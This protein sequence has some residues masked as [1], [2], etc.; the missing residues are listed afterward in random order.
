M[1]HRFLALALCGLC[2][3]VLT[4]APSAPPPPK[5][6]DAQLRYQ[7]N[8][9]RNER[10][11]QYAEMSEDLKAAGFQRDPDEEVADDEP[12][13]P[14]ATR[15]R[16][17]IPA[18]GVARLLKQRHVRTLL[19]QPKGTKL[20]GKGTRVRID[21]E[22]MP[23]YSPATQ[24]RIA[25]QTAAALTKG[26]GF[27][28][29][30]HYDH[31]GDTRL[32]GSVPVENLP[33]LLEDVRRLPGLKDKGESLK[34]IPAIRAV[35][36]H[37][38][39]PVPASRPAA[40]VIPP[41]QEKFTPDLRALLADAGKAGTPA[42]L[43]VILGY[44]PRADDRTWQRAVAL[45]GVVVEGRLGPLVTVQGVPKAIAG[46]LAGSDEVVTVRLPREARLAP[47]G[48]RGGGP[49]KWEPVKASGLSRLHALGL[50]G[51]GT[52]I[53]LVASDFHGWETLKNRKEGKK[54]L[55]DPVFLDLTSERKRDLLG[56]PFPSGGKDVAQGHGTR[57]AAALLKAAPEA[58]L[59]LIRIDSAAPYMMETAARA[60]NGEPVRTVAMASRYAELEADL[61]SL[62]ARRDGLVEER[63]RALDD[64]RDDPEAIKRRKDYLAKQAAF[65]KEVQDHRVRQARYLKL[66]RD[67]KRLQGIRL[68]ASA[69][70]WP[71]GYPV[72]G[73]STLSRYFDDRPFRAALWFQAAGDTAGQAWTGLFRDADENGIMEFADPKERLPADTWSPELNFL[74]WRVG[75]KQERDLPAGAVIRLTLQWKEAH[76]PGPLRVGEDVYRE[77]LAKMKMVLVYQPDPN[78]KARPADDLEVVAQTAG[79]PQRLN[80]TLNSATW[81]QVLE[82]RVTKA[83]RY[84]VFIEGKPPESIH[85]VGEV[86]LPQSKKVSELRVRLFASTLAGAGRAVWSSFT[87]KAAALGM[88]ADARR[89]IAVGAVAG[90]GRIRGSSASG[91]PF[92]LALVTKPDVYAYDEGAG[93]GQA[94]SFAAGLAASSW[95]SRGTLFGILEALGVSPG[96]V[97][98]IP[99]KRTK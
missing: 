69:L 17:T 58:E 71:E 39:W 66:L 51:R 62:D 25:T 8:A 96:G 23:G 92:N 42:R 95:G 86:H 57:C 63:R 84:G 32:V 49:A 77:P 45:P 83:G 10:L 94:A 19:L 24:K 74:A 90:D 78:G 2:A 1:L 11:R 18:K 70:V 80:Q 22:L 4:A 44:T 29:A 64:F 7:I 79:L 35:Y 33:R 52:R 68:V 31:R 73:S 65:D 6:W 93:T 98:R 28:E 89:V 40:P 81:E 87:T 48:P 59:T 27:I 41:G 56:D 20:P 38:E 97:L 75:E 60:I 15:M 3:A 14:K 54:L 85:G 72:D 37:P 36:V 21:I 46:L 91:S 50:R 47:P 55:P 53:A 43:E 30:V 61:A 13:N 34:N 76:H 12:E 26:A 67:L 5:V 16:G 88:P 9:F 82:F 99:D